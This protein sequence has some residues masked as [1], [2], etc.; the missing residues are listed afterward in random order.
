MRK[1]ERAKLRMKKKYAFGRPGAID[2]IRWPK[3]FSDSPE[4]AERREKITSKSVIYDVTLVDWVDRIDVD[5]Q[6]QIF[7]Q[8]L[9]KARR[10]EHEHANEEAD[11]VQFNMRIYQK[12]DEVPGEEVKEITLVDMKDEMAHI[13]E[14]KC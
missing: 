8:T 7:K 6:G 5:A 2:K 13:Y 3:G 10:N 14:L 11:Q 9:T 1:G 4:D 12:T